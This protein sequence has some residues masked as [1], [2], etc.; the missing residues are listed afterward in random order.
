MHGNLAYIVLIGAWG[1]YFFL[2][3]FLV[4]ERVKIYLH[5]S[6]GIGKTKQR[7]F[8]SF[9]SIVGLFLLLVING[10]IE[11]EPLI[12]LSER[13]KIISMFIS[14]AG[15]L[16]IRAG[17]KHYSL[18]AFLGL[19]EESSDFISNGVLSKVR[20]PIYSGTILI[21]VGFFL[22]DP[23][24][25]T[26]VSCLTIFVY[27]VIGIRLEENKLIKVHGDE[28]KEYKKKVPMLIPKINLF[29]K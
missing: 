16:I 8:Y 7:L 17:F 18:K 15:L 12:P 27:L 2:H 22:F 5:S 4:T 23:R 24:I 9:I 13:L 6:L 25:A 1:V 10:A 28:Y 26:L 19:Q 3:S 21:V 20:H 11:S 14:T 29:G